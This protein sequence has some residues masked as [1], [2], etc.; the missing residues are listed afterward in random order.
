LHHE[1][2]YNGHSYES[3][4]EYLRE[5]ARVLTLADRGMNAVMIRRVTGRSMALV[6]AYMDLYRKY[7][8]P[9]YHFRLAQIRQVFVREEEADQKGGPTSFHT[10]DG[11]P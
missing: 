3:V 11:L 5:F 2:Q 10:K 4:E 1:L 6:Q 9:D 8:E 7:D